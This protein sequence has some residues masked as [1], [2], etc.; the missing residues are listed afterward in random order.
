MIGL[1]HR[2]VLNTDVVVRPADLLRMPGLPTSESDEFVLTRTASRSPSVQLNREAAEF[3]LAFSEPCSLLAAVQLTARR[4]G[5]PEQQILEEV[6]PNLTAFIQR[7]I[8]VRLSGARRD[9]KLPQ[10]GAWRL[11]RR[12]HDFD[13]SSV[14]LA[15]NSTGEFGA[16]KLA[17]RPNLL[18]IIER[19]K[20]VLE[21]LG[22]SVSPRLLD[23]GMSPQGAYLVAEWKPGAVAAN[24]F[25]E[26]RLA[27]APRRRLL[28]AAIHVVEAFAEMHSRGVLHGDIQPK[29]VLFDLQQRVWLIDFSHSVVPG[30]PAPAV[31]MG[32]PFF[33]EPEYARGL[34]AEP[35]VELGITLKGE[36]YAVG[37]L[38]FYL[39]SGVYAIE[40]S[41]EREALLKQV[42]E[43]EPRPLK[44]PQGLHWEPAERAI[45]A[46]LAKD[47]EQRP[48][49]LGQV[50]GM[51]AG[52]LTAEVVPENSSPSAPAVRFRPAPEAEIKGR[53]GLG[54]KAL[55]D[56]EVIAPRC[57]LSFG[58]TG[59]AYALLRV[60]QLSSDPELLWAADA[61]IEKAL[62]H[63]KEPEAFT[64]AAIDLTRRKIGYASL[65]GAEPGVHFTHALVRAAAGDLRG[66][67]SAIRDFLSAAT[68][69]P[70]HH[71]DV[72]LG[73]PGL[74]LAAHSLA[75]IPASMQLRLKL[76][77][78][79][80]DLVARAWRKA[81]TSN[82]KR[83]GFAHGLAGLAFAALVCGKAED[84]PQ[85]MTALRSQTV[86]LD[87]GVRWPVQI[88][89]NFFMPG[90]CNGVAGHLLLW[91][92]LWKQSA[93]DQD[94]EMLER[95]AWGV[96][97]S[98]SNLG[99]V[100]CGGSGQAVALACFAAA[101]GDPV[102]H[103]RATQLIDKLKPQWPKD[104]RPQS[105]FRGELGMLLAQI[106]CHAEAEVVFPV[107]G[108]GL[109][110]ATRTSSS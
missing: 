83:L 76:D 11:Q 94:R 74:A 86:P 28:E 57:S 36:I 47:P 35:P 34:L 59:I 1:N 31:R 80:R 3:L 42:L 65:S 40:F 62:Q 82:R 48:E 63:C 108:M 88:D 98:R 41:L 107:W 50:R 9:A 12:I 92:M 101:A 95:V 18:G 23:S 73:G 25:Q 51:L 44:D 64:S 26:L 49:S 16:L 69:R 20:H 30:L 29:N 32:V 45:R 102:W 4:T 21:L 60:A 104:D 71:G 97:E 67:D 77:A 68:A 19:E 15:K 6:Y 90:W 37:A 5:H 70:S 46:C 93:Q 72:N 84:T 75:A 54:S 99:N 17:R 79:S 66:T 27:P 56:F 106:E 52:A 103:S 39:L 96:W 58:A 87:K 109:S 55:R 105:L 38:L 110:M 53:F 81:A 61:W 24:V 7:G 13:D 85:V 33:Y 10:I 91:T 2:L 89:G 100:C 22:G 43:V 14:F 8:L 78:L